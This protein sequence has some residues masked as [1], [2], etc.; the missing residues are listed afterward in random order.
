MRICTEIKREVFEV[1]V[2]VRKIKEG[3]FAFS[4]EV[5]M[6]EK[7][8][9]LVVSSGQSMCACVCSVLYVCV[10]CMGVCA[11]VC[12][13]VCVCECVCVCVGDVG[14]ITKPDG[15][16]LGQLLC[17]QQSWRIYAPSVSSTSSMS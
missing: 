10:L 11:C 6:G 12:V 9:A 2:S 4:G 17:V 7:C 15:G 13:F 14:V 16:A 3:N 1:R 8:N 5:L